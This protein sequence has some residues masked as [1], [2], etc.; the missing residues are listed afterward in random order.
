MRLRILCVLW[1]RG[2]GRGCAGFAGPTMWA[3][4]AGPVRGEPGR[5]GPSRFG[6]G[7]YIYHEIPW[8][9]WVG[10]NLLEPDD[11]GLG[12]DEGSFGREVLSSWS[13]G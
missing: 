7:P 4:L 2:A 8:S 9:G 11:L 12:G 3:G 1:G 5:A 13:G 6:A 10:Q